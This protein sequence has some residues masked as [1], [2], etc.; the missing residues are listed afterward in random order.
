MALL[1]FRILKDGDLH[2]I[3]FLTLNSYV[4]IE[5][6][7]NGILLWTIE[8]NKIMSEFS[9]KSSLQVIQTN[10][11]ISFIFHLGLFIQLEWS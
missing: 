11:C 9:L 8:A 10:Q 7:N 4:G 5:K 6:T 1:V 3:P 2:L